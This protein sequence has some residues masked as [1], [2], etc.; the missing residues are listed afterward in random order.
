MVEKTLM[1]PSVFTS[2]SEGEI[3]I[4]DDKYKKIKKTIK[5]YQKFIKKTRWYGI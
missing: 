4:K 1:S 3:T 2:K 5:E